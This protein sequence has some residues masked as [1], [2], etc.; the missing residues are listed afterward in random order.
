MSNGKTPLRRSGRS[1]KRKSSGKGDDDVQL[2]G[3]E[4]S[5]VTNS[6]KSSV[7]LKVKKFIQEANRR[8][9]A[10]SARKH[11]N[12]HNKYSSEPATKQHSDPVNVEDL[13][14]S[15]AACGTTVTPLS[16]LPLAVSESATSLVTDASVISTAPV[17][18]TAPVTTTAPSTANVSTQVTPP[19]LLPFL[20]DD[21]FVVEAPSFVVPYVY[22]TPSIKPFREF[23]NNL[24]KQLEEQRV[25]EEKEKSNKQIPCLV[26]E[27]SV[28][29]PETNAEKGGDEGKAHK[30]CK[31]NTNNLYNNFT[32]NSYYL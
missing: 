17:T 32:E 21:M 6:T 19:P 18:A 28:Q 12:K 30:K 13:Y 26:P 29:K 25:R 27:L 24:G 8:K 14:Q 31:Y 2:V 5:I 3:M 16:K 20:T 23:V 11:A 22:E 7:F 10:D 4:S 9:T 1:V 15:I